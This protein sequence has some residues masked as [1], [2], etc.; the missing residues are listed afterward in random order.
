MD[1]ASREDE[2]A[3]LTAKLRVLEEAVGKVKKI[4]EALCVKLFALTYCAEQVY[5]ILNKES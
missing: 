3:Q 1:P 2:I 4:N 5:I